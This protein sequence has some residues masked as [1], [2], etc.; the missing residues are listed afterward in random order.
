MET[1]SD[2]SLV[3]C[4]LCNQFFTT[5]KPHVHRKHGIT[6]SE[7]NIRFPGGPTITK[8]L[9]KEWSESVSKSL[10]G[11]TRSPLHNL[12]LAESLQKWRDENPDL[13]KEMVEG[14]RRANTG[15]ALD[16]V[17]R[18]NIAKGVKK[19]REED[20]SLNEKVSKA[21]GAL[22]RDPVHRAARTKSM[23]DAGK[24]L[25]ANPDYVEKVTRGRQ[26]KPNKNEKALL[27]LLRVEYPD[28]WLYSGDGS[29][30]NTLWSWGYTGRLKPDFLRSKGP[31]QV[32]FLNNYYWHPLIDEEYQKEAFEKTN[33]TC[34]VIWVHD[35][36]MVTQK[37]PEIKVLIEDRSDSSD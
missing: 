4:K 27:E 29:Q 35:E 22:W 33:I 30:I 19:A 24:A 32:I 6:L 17:W 5:L 2:E 16:P 26:E 23:S 8:A 37:W 25:W 7:Y 14:A 1:E 11:R 20:P 21:Q 15:R 12:H 28:Q 10:T 18:A 31:R 36:Y 13:V 3:E 9:N 34:I